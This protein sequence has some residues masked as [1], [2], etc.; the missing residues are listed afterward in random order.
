MWNRSYHWQRNARLAAG[1]AVLVMLAASVVV[2]DRTSPA[3]RARAGARAL[4]G[5]MLTRKE[6]LVEV[7]VPTS[8]DAR[9]GTLVYLER[10]DG[11]AQVIGRVVAVDA[12]N[13]TRSNQHSHDGAGRGFDEPRRHSVLRHHARL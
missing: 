5:E 3:Q 6:P 8:L 11:V 4:A 2:L 13:E 9:E 10:D 1:A 7:D 12:G